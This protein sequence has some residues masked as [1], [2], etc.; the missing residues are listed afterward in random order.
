MNGTSGVFIHIFFIQFVFVQFVCM[1]RENYAAYQG[2]NGPNK[3]YTWF[4]PINSTF[5][6]ASLYIAIHIPAIQKHIY[7]VKMRCSRPRQNT[8]S[9]FLSRR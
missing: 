9:E 1:P 5:Y 7:E 3:I 6:E 8:I 4:I 2:I